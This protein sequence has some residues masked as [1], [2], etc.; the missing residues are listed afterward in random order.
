MDNKETKKEKVEFKHLKE[1]IGRRQVVVPQYVKQIENLLE[2]ISDPT[3]KKEVN[4][5]LTVLKNYEEISNM[6]GDY[7]KQMLDYLTR[8]YNY[9][10][11]KFPNIIIE[12]EGRIKSPI[13]ADNKIRG[14]INEYRG[15]NRDIENLPNSLR[16][17]FGYSYVIIAPGQP[18]DQVEITYQVLAAQM[19]FQKANGFEFIPVG[20]EKQAKI[21]ENSKKETKFIKGVKKLEDNK[22]FKGFFKLKETPMFKNFFKTKAEKKGVY[23]PTSRPDVI[24]KYDPYFK[25]YMMYPK[26]TLYQSAQ[27][28]VIPFAMKKF[29]LEDK[30]ARHNNHKP[31]E[32]LEDFHRLRIPFKFNVLTDDTGQTKVVQ[33]PYDEVIK[34][35]YGHDFYTKFGIYYGDFITL[36]D[37][38][39]AGNYHVELID[40][41]YKVI[42]TPRQEK[43]ISVIKKAFQK[44]M[45]EIKHPEN[46]FS[47][48]STD[49]DDERDDIFY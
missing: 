28:C 43:P 11:E 40:G 37:Q 42:K 29:A 25:D 5:Y 9:L 33:K 14:K 31:E 17:F 27:Y 3:Y 7:I 13:S 38:I 32:V 46:F 1:F 49:I 4:A 6:N 8:E 45:Y 20:E 35:I 12:A 16:D 21:K 2:M 39:S 24:E 47:Y 44:A 15:K 36:F 18:K 48:S 26:D 19:E 41:E 22:I 10:K 30:D 23:I 34:E